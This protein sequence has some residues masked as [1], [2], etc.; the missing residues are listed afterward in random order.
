MIQ[1]RVGINDFLAY[2]LYDALSYKSYNVLKNSKERQKWPAP[3]HFVGSFVLYCTLVY[4][5]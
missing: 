2:F 4:V 5:L 1:E 3:N